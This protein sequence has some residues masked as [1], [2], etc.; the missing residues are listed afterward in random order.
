MTGSRATLAGLVGVLVVA[1][2]SAGAAGALVMTGA[3]PQTLALAPSSLEVPVEARP[4]A[5]ERAITL[6]VEVAPDVPLTVTGGGRITAIDCAPGTVWVS[7]EVALRVDGSPIVS[8]ATG[9][10]LWRD[11]A[12]GD[13]GDDVA[14]L[15]TELERLGAD[16]R[17]DGI[18]TRST[19][20]AVDR[21]LGTPS[22][23]SGNVSAS[24]IL[25][26]PAVST[27]IASCP[28]FA[29]SPLAPGEAVAFASGTPAVELGAVP[30]DLVEGPR[31]VRVEGAEI[32]TLADGHLGAEAGAA[33]LQT[34]AYR[35]ALA[36]GAT[37]FELQAVLALA[38]SASVASVPPAAIYD[39]EGRA[40]CVLATAGPVAVTVLGSQLG[41]TYVQFAEE[42]PSSVVSSPR[43]DASPC[44]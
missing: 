44:R 36:E 16:V 8:L 30:A 21:L 15:E 40:G 35:G 28:A 43:S 27:E 17:N 34:S 18:V 24:R 2:L 14:A 38:E 10:P 4:F 39:L 26:L 29:G 12:V 5:D 13:R 20:A 23:G 6:T 41:R 11:L 7:G 22:A 32:A 9:T 31:V 33:V 19:V 3:T 42:P 25:W 37:R 1:L